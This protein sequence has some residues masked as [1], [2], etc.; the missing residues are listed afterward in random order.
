MNAIA[1]ESISKDWIECVGNKLLIFQGLGG[2]GK[3]IRMLQL[4][5]RKYSEQGAN[6]LILTYNR[7][8]IS[9]L[10]RLM[11]VMGISP[12]DDERGGIEIASL[13]KFMYDIYDEF[14]MLL[15]LKTKKNGVTFMQNYLSHLQSI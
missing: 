6:T 1:K 15:D 8:L 9:N 13:E 10:Q 5:Y 7:A 12:H 14:K 2:T 4:A 3:T 11:A